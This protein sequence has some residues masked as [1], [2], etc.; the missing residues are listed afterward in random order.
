MADF[1]YVAWGNT[2]IVGKWVIETGESGIYRGQCTQVVSQLLK[3]LGYPAYGTA[4][5]NG[6]QVGPYMVTHGEATYEG[7]NLSSIPSNEIHVIC[8]DVGGAGAGHVSVAAFGDIVYEQ[9]VN[10]GGGTQNYGIG[11]TYSGRLGR[12]A[13]A[14]RGTR[15]HYKLIIDTDFD[16]VTGSGDDPGDPSDD[17]IGPNQNRFLRS[18]IIDIQKMKLNRSSSVKNHKQ[19]YLVKK[20][21]RGV[22]QG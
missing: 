17:P 19:Y 2:K 22:N 3:D 7:T 11:P 21:K 1:D 8:R 13:E 10:N 14:W 6:N 4:R 20:T 16:N 12:L 15:Y 5:G 18:N 9:N